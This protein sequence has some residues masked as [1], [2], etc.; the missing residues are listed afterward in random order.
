MIKFR[1]FVRDRSPLSVGIV[2]FDSF[3]VLLLCC[4]FGVGLVFVVRHFFFFS[5]FFVDVI[6]LLILVV[7]VV[8]GVFWSVDHRLVR[9]IKEF[10]RE[11]FNDACDGRTKL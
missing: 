4:L 3:I 2:L 10:R 8:F 5:S 7:S 11:S 6:S 9:F 1:S